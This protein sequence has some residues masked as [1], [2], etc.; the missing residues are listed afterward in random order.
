MN[1]TARQELETTQPTPTRQHPKPRAAPNAW[2]ISVVVVDDDPADSSLIVDVLQRH[3]KVGSVTAYHRPEEALAAL[4]DGK[5]QPDLILL[6]ISM[7]KINGFKFVEMIDLAPRVRQTPIVYLTTSRFAR[8][9]Q[10][11]RETS[12]C[13]YI[14]KPESFD[15]LRQRLDAAIKQTISGKWS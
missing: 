7:P 12:A 9:V 13:A 3:P 4:A 14:V 8:D 2:R 15:E 5:R 6:D 11:A 10:Q 1:T